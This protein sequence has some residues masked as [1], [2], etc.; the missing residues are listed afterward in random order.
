[1]K[2]PLSVPFS[3]TAFEDWI[4]VYS[5]ANIEV[6]DRQYTYIAHMMRANVLAFNGIPFVFA[7]AVQQ[8]V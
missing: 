5:P 7:D 4:R 3:L 1:M 8:Q 2:L 6:T